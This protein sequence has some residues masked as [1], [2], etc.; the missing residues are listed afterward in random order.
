MLENVSNLLCYIAIARA[1]KIKA[2]KCRS[3]LEVTRLFH[4]FVA[5]ILMV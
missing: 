5:Q 4:W 3:G 2:K 1:A